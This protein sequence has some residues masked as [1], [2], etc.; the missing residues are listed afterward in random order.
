MNDYRILIHFP[1]AKRPDKALALVKE[2]GRLLGTTNYFIQLSCD[3]DDESMNND[4]VRARVAEIENC[5]IIY[6]DNKTKNEAFNRGL[7]DTEWDIVI[8]GSDDMFPIVQNYGMI[9]CDFF[10]KNIQD[11]DGV[12]R[13]FDGHQ[14]TINILPIIGRKY[15]ERFNYIFNEEYGSFYC[16]NEFTEVSQML[17]KEFDSKLQ[18]FDHRHPS[19]GQAQ[20]DQ[21]YVDNDNKYWNSDGEV[22]KRRKAMNFGVN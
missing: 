12:M 16:D 10:T 3:V 21:L 14:R 4:E 15:F 18:L 17:G 7:V 1:T 2:Y 5:S 11:L 8:V 22:Y 9:V 19:R 13:T 6:H 20:T